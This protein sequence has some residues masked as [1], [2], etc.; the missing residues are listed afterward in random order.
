MLVERG[1]GGLTLDS[2][3]GV[4]VPECSGSSLAL[5]TAVDAMSMRSPL[6][7]RLSAAWGASQ[8]SSP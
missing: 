7:N 8:V 4:V 5:T 3:L 6:D 2:R 1:E